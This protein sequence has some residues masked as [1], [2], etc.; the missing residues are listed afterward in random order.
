[1]PTLNLGKSSPR[2]EIFIFLNKLPHE[3]AIPPHCAKNAGA[4][5]QRR[6]DSTKIEPP[7]DPQK[8]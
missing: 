7:N 5:S 2:G 1:M 4:A 6:R 8:M 3:A